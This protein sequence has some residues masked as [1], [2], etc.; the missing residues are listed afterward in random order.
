[1]SSVASIPDVTN[2]TVSPIERDPKADFGFRRTIE[3]RNKHGLEHTI[4]ITSVDRSDLE[5]VVPTR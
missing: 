2:V 4:L 3:I 1:M 5:F